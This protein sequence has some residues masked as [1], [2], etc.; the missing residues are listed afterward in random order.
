MHAVYMQSF[1]LDI[2]GKKNKYQSNLTGEERSASP[3]ARRVQPGCER[4]EARGN[5]KGWLTVWFLLGEALPGRISDRD[6]GTNIQR[7]RFFTWTS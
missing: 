1:F 2:F 6:V 7:Y 5:F 4:V 3:A